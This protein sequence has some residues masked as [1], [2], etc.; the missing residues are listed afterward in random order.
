MKHRWVVGD[1]N[2]VCTWCA[3]EL[4][5]TTE[6]KFLAMGKRAA[7]CLRMTQEAADA[8]A[9]AIDL[10]IDLW[11][12]A[13]IK[14]TLSPEASREVNRRQVSRRR[15]PGGLIAALALAAM[16]PPPRRL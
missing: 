2:I 15:V 14:D 4:P 5:R 13:G 8:K 12:A 3:Q 11:R 16:P 10:E 6:G 1:T 9:D 7:G